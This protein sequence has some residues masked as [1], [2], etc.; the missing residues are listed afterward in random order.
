[1]VTMAHEMKTANLPPR[2]HISVVEEDK[3]VVGRDYFDVR[4]RERLFDTPSAIA[5]VVKSTKYE[6]R[7][8]VSAEGSY[9]LNDRPLR[10]HWAVLRGEPDRIGHRPAV[11]KARPGRVGSS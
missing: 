10:F 6:R 9:D 3:G 5:R 4:P 11:P 2:V 1:M 7:M 8:V